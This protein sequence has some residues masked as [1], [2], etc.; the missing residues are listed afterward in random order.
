MP[1][2]TKRTLGSPEITGDLGAKIALWLRPGDFIAL[3]GPLG[4]GKTVLA[5]AIISALG[6]SPEEVPSP[7]FTLV[8]HY[9]D[10]RLPAAHFDLYR[11][12]EQGE[13]DE[14]GIEDALEAG[15]VL[16]E[17]ADRFESALPSD[18]LE[19]AL[20]DTSPDMR[21][22]MLIG[23]GGWD[24]R[25]RR[26]VDLAAFIDGAGWT[27]ARRQWLKGDASTRAYERLVDP[28]SGQSAL[29]MN[30]PRGPDGPP[31]R[32]GLS[33]SRIAHLAED[34]NAFVAVDRHLLALDLSAPQILAA[35]T[36]RGFLLIED[37]GNCLYGD[38]I[39]SHSDLSAPYEAAVDALCRIHAAP[40]PDGLAIG[41]SKM[42]PLS[43][44]DPA[45]MLIEVELL[46]DW[47]WPA[48]KGAPC[49]HDI[50]EAYCDAWSN[51]LASLGGPEVLTLRDFHSPNLIWLPEREG[52]ARAGLIDFQDAVIGHPAYDL[53]S[54]AQDARIDLPD[55][56][57]RH[58]VDY[59]L[60]CRPAHVADISRDHFEADYALL[61]AQ[62]AA[63]IAGIFTRLAE[64]D[65]KPDYLAHMPRVLEF[66]RA[67]LVHPRLAEIADWFDEHVE[68]ELEIGRCAATA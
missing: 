27:H 9:P 50:R 44:Y 35:D 51:N 42:H 39:A 57:E 23:H 60:A 11:I 26:S 14:L 48:W 45:A 33:Y 67:N 22:A 12:S 36:G 49:P 64:R 54:L 63:K 68:L 4:A 13:L 56:L 20:E 24:A 43:R 34:V 65:G 29:V 6:P 37:L 47:A 59:W 17:W 61:G 1:F 52:A 16:V 55:G 46:V 19:I 7:S 38:L 30:A 10:L 32:D 18:R 40:P 25:L 53:V 28:A 21:E 15:L 58:I 2:S 62:R 31:V 8:Q 41:D 3:T 5:R 66:L